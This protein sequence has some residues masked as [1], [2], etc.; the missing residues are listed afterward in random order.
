MAPQHQDPGQTT[1]F[2]AS[3]AEPHQTCQLK[4][5]LVN[6]GFSDD[7]TCLLQEEFRRFLEKSGFVEE[8]I[9][10]YINNERRLLTETTSD[11][12][13]RHPNWRHNTVEWQ[14]LVRTRLPA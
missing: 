3:Q 14:Q 13:S 9:D 1:N 5:S 7:D 8:V 2:T 4:S 10:L 12:D 11:T 6:L